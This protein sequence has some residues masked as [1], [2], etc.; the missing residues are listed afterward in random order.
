MFGREAN[1]SLQRVQLPTPIIAE[2]L[3]IIVIPG[4]WARTRACMRV[5]AHGCL[6]PNSKKILVV[7][8]CTV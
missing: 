5:E 4:S 7:S 6:V 2:R 8:S 3:R 1:P